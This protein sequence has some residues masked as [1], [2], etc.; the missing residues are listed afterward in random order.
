MFEATFATAFL[1]ATEYILKLFQ[2]EDVLIEAH[3]HFCDQ[4]NRN[5]CHILGPNGVQMLTVPLKQHADKTPVQ[6]I[7]VATG[8]WKVRHW[9]SIETAYNRS[10]LFEYYRDE[11]K[12]V[13]FAEEKF[14]LQYN[15]ML[16]QFLLNKAKV[17]TTLSFTA[18]YRN[19]VENDYRYLS[20]IKTNK[21]GT[22]LF[23]TPYPQVFSD[24]FGFVTNL[25]FMDFLFNSGV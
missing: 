17:H 24:K 13:F 15:Q 25:S 10:A 7:E 12:S 18:S 23:L 4:T 9:R 19:T 21:Q 11:F 22:D 14:L 3:E 5:R 16:L 2:F 20:D 1:P 8:N 6:E